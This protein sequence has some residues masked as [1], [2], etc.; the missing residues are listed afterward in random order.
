MT[1]GVEAPLAEGDKIAIGAFTIIR[2]NAV[3]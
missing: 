1:A 2:V 3:R